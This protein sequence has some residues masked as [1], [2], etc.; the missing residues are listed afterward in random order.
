MKCEQSLV[1]VVVS[2]SDDVL[3]VAVDHSQHEVAFCVPLECFLL[4]ITLYCSPPKQKNGKVKFHLRRPNHVLNFQC[5]YL[6]TPTIS[7]FADRE[8]FYEK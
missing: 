4:F 1:E 5:L 3:P 7:V 2:R 8:A 6:N